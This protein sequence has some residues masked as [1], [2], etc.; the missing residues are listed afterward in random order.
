MLL[1]F[2]RIASGRRADRCRFRVIHS[3][4]VRL[5]FGHRR[6]RHHRRPTPAAT[7][8]S[9]AV[10]VTQCLRLPLLP[11]T[12]ALHRLTGYTVLG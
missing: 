3:D 5:L 9:R 7:A 2:P 12:V 1:H 6:H 11:A 4:P 8:V 10:T